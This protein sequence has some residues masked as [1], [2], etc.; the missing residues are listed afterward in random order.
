MSISQ[1]FSIVKN[2][3]EKSQT[4]TLKDIAV[5]FYGVTKYSEHNKNL[6]LKL[7]RKVQYIL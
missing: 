6:G 7:R 2:L 1:N 5:C 3:S 4:S